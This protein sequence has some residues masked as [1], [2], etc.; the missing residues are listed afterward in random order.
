MKAIT[1]NT[2]LALLDILETI[3]LE[4]IFIA[5]HLWTQAFQE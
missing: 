5:F 2:S 4:L 1:A 3:M